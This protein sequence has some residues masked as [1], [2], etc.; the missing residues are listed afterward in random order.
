[1]VA[2]A[3][4]QQFSITNNIIDAH[5]HL[6]RYSPT[7]YDWIDDSMPQLRHDFLPDDLAPIAAAAGVTAT[8][9]VQ[10]RQSLDETDWLL[11]LAEN[12]PLIQ[13][14][15]G[16]APIA[17]PDFPAWLDQNAARPKLAGLRHIVQ[18][19]PDPEFLLQPAFAEGIRA[20][21][22][23]NLVYDIL[24]YD[25][26]LPQAI[27]F[28][29]QHPNQI[30]VLDHIAKPRITEAVLE[31]WAFNITS[32]AQRPNV[33]CKLS[34]MVT[35]ANWTAWTP[36]TLQPYFD[37]VLNAFTPQRL[38]LGS[39]WPVCLLATTYARW[40]TLLR[41]IISSFSTDEQQRILSGTAQKVYNIA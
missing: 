28:V 20:L 27:R 17:S 12:S 32:L 2:L 37:A 40:F 24:I 22:R 21:T 30:F 7:E 34:G 4:D 15:V 11:S 39:D 13:A 26:Q 3:D 33:F 14:V 19:E 25:S 8:V 41:S 36:A 29:D 16:W 9:A 23:S 1:V 10:A 31:P 38:M 35:E 18:A 6:W 5:H